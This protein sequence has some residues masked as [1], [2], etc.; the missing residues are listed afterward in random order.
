MADDPGISEI[1]FARPP[2][3]E[4][5][6]ERRFAEPFS[7]EVMEDLRRK[8]E[9]DYPAISQLNSMS[10]AIN[11]LGA[12]PE[13]SQN[14]VGYRLANL[15]GDAIV[16]ITTQSLA[17][18]RL[19]P[20]PG[21]REFSKQG[22]GLFRVARK[23][24]DY[25]QI[26]RIGVRYVNRLDI[27]FTLEQG[28]PVPIQMEDYILIHPEYPAGLFPPA[29]SYSMQAVTLLPDIHSRLTINVATVPSPFPGRTGIIFDID[30]GRESE[31]PQ[32][33][34]E[35]SNIL[36]AI[37]SEKNRIFLSCLTDKAK[38]LFS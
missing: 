24:M 31:I 17:F 7:H 21:W 38:A 3:V 5:V 27:P 12:V 11:A 16:V 20:Y 13:V 19:A 23:M 14:I 34:D 37:R 4:A 15:S 6:I 25:M 36:D 35:I 32:R 1:S 22:T 29:Q 26:G 9:S 10:W 2:I 30:I 18:A 28:T 8:L 33:E